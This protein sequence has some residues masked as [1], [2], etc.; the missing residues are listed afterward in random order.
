MTSP[1]SYSQLDL[2][3]PGHEPRLL[4][5]PHGPES[6]CSCGWQS[7]WIG[8]IADAAEEIRGHIYQVD[9][10]AM[11]PE[12]QA[13]EFRAMDDYVEDHRHDDEATR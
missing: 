4:H 2:T 3:R 5:G 10:D 1:G 7:E 12:E 13:L 8:S 6:T 11:T 9:L